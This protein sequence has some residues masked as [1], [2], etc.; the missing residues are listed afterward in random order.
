MPKLGDTLAATAAGC[1]IIAGVCALEG[2]FV[3]N[4]KDPGGA[5]NH[6]VTE[7]VARAHGY[8]GDMRQLPQQYAAG[9]LYQ[10]YVVKPGFAPFVELSPAVA[11]ELVDSAVNTGPKQPSLWLQLALNALSQEGKAYP[12]IPVDGK[13][14]EQTVHAY[15]GLV[16]AR[17]KTVACQLMLKSLDGQ[18]AAYYL[19]ISTS[20]PKLQEFTA[21]WMLN[22]VGNVSLSRCA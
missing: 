21:G 6:G 20:T 17:G 10:D 11:A 22:R 15:E 2:G 19:Q 9:I 12:Q 14:G 8:T 7:S 1:A 4:P 16:K 13:I 5:T 18:Q 3:N